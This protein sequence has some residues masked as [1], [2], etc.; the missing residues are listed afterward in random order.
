V[1]LGI[2]GNV[3]GNDQSV[4]SFSTSL[5]YSVTS[6]GGSKLHKFQPR[7]HLART[8][9]PPLHVRLT[10]GS[11]KQDEYWITLQM[12]IRALMEN[13]ICTHLRLMILYY[14]CPGQQ[15]AQGQNQPG[16]DCK[17]GP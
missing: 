6:V 17:P 16:L 14:K 13:G 15:A 9:T 4:T 7:L 8:S 2:Y 10:A 3:Y 5:L 12:H 1:K 11:W